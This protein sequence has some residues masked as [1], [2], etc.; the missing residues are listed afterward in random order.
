MDLVELEARFMDLV[1]LEFLEL[2]CLAE[3]NGGELF[4]IWSCVELSGTHHKR[5]PSMT[6]ADTMKI[7]TPYSKY[8]TDSQAQQSPCS[9]GLAA[10]SQQYF[11]LRTNQP[12][13][14]SQQC[15][16]LRTNQHQPSATSPTNRLRA[17]L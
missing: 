4:F 15:F 3:K 8:E 11:S 17:C 1:D 6:S 7:C 12:L 13:A 5:A 9:F 16:S 10:T 14:T 2:G